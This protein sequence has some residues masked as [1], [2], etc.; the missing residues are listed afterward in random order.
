MLLGLILTYAT[1]L[2]L[3]ANILAIM[4]ADAIKAARRRDR[5]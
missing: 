3:I 5:S 2:G 1:S 4:A